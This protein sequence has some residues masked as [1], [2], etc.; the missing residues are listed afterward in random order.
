[1]ESRG[2]D[3]YKNEAVSPAMVRVPKRRFPRRSL[4]LV[5]L[6]FMCCCVPVCGYV[7]VRP[8]VYTIQPIGALPEGVTFIYHSRNPE[9]PFFS[10]PDGMCLEIQGSVTLLCRATALAASEDLTDRI[11]IRLPYSRWAYLM[12]TGGR[13]F[14]Q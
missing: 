7:V 8:G 13:E 2:A 11:I 6:V 1:M 10:S 3:T 14:E 12:S 5:V 4:A 9:M